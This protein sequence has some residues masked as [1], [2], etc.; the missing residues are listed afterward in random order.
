MS[1]VFSVEPGIGL[2]PCSHFLH[3]LVKCRGAGLDLLAVD[4][5]EYRHNLPIV[6][7]FETVVTDEIL[8]KCRVGDIS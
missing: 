3:L 4:L 8:Q 5:S 7:V 1:L 6:A 2:V